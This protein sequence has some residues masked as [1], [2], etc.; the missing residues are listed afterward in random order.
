MRI[1]AEDGS[2]RPRM[3]RRRRFWNWNR[4]PENISTE[5]AHSLSNQLDTV[6]VPAQVIF[7]LRSAFA[8]ATANKLPILDRLH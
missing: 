7:D 5:S 4:D 3:K 1:A 2:S 8:K 6:Q